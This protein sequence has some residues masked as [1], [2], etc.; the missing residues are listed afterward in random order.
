MKRY[1]QFENLLVDDLEVDTWPHPRHNHN[2]FE[3]VSI[4]KGSGIHDLNG[5]KSPYR[6][7][8]LFLLG[9]DD[10]HEF[11]IHERTRFL[12][13]KFTRAYI[14]EQPGM[15]LP[16]DWHKTID[17]LLNYPE[18]KKG[19]LLSNDDDRDLACRIM[20]AIIVEFRA[21]NYLRSEMIYQLFTSL[22]ILIKRNRTIFELLEHQNVDESKLSEEI[23]KYVEHHIYS[24][25]HLTLKALAKE[26]HY[27][28]NYMGVL[29]KE[30]IGETLSS[31][32]STFRLKLI[33]D[34]LTFSLLSMKEIAEEFGFVDESHLNR[35]VKSKTGKAPSL[36]RN[37]TS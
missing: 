2:H 24:P 3:I 33:K 7:H 23:L 35:F 14:A 16:N 18:R 26:F 34:R 5:I 25:E 21:D 30:V 29:F 22:V 37:R 4:A 27:T 13:F 10:E 11:E 15:A 31:Y 28:P 20:K 12:Y 1:K 36:I 19:N 6:Q 8:D 9:L 32:T 17:Q